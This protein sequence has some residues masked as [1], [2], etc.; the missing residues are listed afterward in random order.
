MG[1]RANGPSHLARILPPVRA[2]HFTSESVTEG[3]P[4]KVAARISDAVLDAVLEIDAFG[5]VACEVLVTGG[6]IV[7]AG[8][9]T[10]TEVPDLEAVARRV[11]ADVLRPQ[12][13]G[14][15]LPKQRESSL[16]RAHNPLSENGH[17]NATVRVDVPCAN[18]T[19]IVRRH[20]DLVKLSQCAAAR[21]VAEHEQPP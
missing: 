16:S 3:H 18:R 11:V 21:V 7:I 14:R 2:W 12:D 15:S 5:R 10:A 6:L 8:E 19:D 4:D 17:V 13:T 1:S 9:I 20:G